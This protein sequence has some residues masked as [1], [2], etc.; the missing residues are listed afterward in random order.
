MCAQTAWT[1]RDASVWV[2]FEPTLRR[3]LLPS[4]RLS[5]YQLRTSEL[6]I[7]KFTSLRCRPSYRAYLAKV[8]FISTNSLLAVYSLVLRHPPFVAPL[9]IYTGLRPLPRHRAQ[10]EG[11][12]DTVCSLRGSCIKA[13]ASH[14]G[15]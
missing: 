9:C 6:Q 2:G 3:C 1:T 10:Q 11:P 14:P 4:F 7:P 15:S 13:G 12:G 5:L 8:W